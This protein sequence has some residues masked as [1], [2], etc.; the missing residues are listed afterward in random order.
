MG[1]AHPGCW[2]KD[3]YEHAYCSL[4]SGKT[5]VDCGGVAGTLWGPHW[6]PACDVK[7]LDRVS[8]NLEALFGGLDVDWAPE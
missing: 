7:R 1:R 4:P 3:H 6:C 2:R 8:A 5:C